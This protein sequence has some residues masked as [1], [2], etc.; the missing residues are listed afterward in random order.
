MRF[1]VHMIA[2]LG[3]VGGMG[4]VTSTLALA[5]EP[6]STT[7]STPLQGTKAPTSPLRVVKGRVPI[8]SVAIMQEVLDSEGAHVRIDGLWGPATE[9]ALRHY[10]KVHGL[11]VTGR[12][13][14]PTRGQLD[15]IG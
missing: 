13:D 3:L 11:E 9:A 4:L 1:V 15:P 7:M 14:Q 6:S 5:A 2:C 8:H 12:L 10:Q